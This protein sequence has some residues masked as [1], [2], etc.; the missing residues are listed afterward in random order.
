MAQ[1]QYKFNKND[2]YYTPSYAV[3][4]IMKRLKS[5]ST[6]WCPFDTEDS[7]FVKVLQSNG[8]NV[9]FGHISTGQD[10]FEV[11]APECDYIISNPPYSLKGEVFKRLYE[12]GKPFAMLINFQGIFDHKERFEMFRNNKIEM[13]WLSP[14]VNYIKENGSTPKGVPFQSGYLCSGIC[15]S[16]LDFE[17]LNKKL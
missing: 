9:E 3:Y 7:E 15:A 8:F 13:L 10:F 11:E 17:Y 6:V 5:N 1:I 2:E 14:R 16:Q 4:P 12:I